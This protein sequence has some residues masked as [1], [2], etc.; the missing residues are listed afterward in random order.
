MN[1]LLP[2]FIVLCLGGIYLVYL[3][4]VYFRVRVPFV[5]S[6][7]HQLETIMKELPITSET[8]IYDLGSG[9]GDVLFEAEK[10]SPKK[11]VGYEISI[12]HVLLSKFIARRRGSRAEFYSKD[13]MHEDFSDADIVYVFLTQDIIR[14]VWPK[15]EDTVREGTLVV[16]LSNRVIGKE[17][18]RTIASDPNDPD[19]RVY[20]IY[21]R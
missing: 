19:S 1:P 20:S 15:I 17:P 18:I 2:A 7:K 12:V 9:M 21:K 6:K 16:M 5:L 4:I 8:I 11:L 13:F 3:V 10:Y 14:T